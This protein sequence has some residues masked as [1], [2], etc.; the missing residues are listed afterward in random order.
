MVSWIESELGDAFDL[1]HV[2]PRNN[3][4]RTYMNDVQ[5]GPGLYIHGD[6]AIAK[7]GRFIAGIGSKAIIITG[8]KSYQAAGHLLE[9]SLEKADVIFEVVAYSGENSDQEASRI[10]T[11]V[12]KDRDLVLG[13]GGGKVMDLGKLVAE[14]LR[15]PYVTVPTLASNCAPTVPVAVVYHPDGSYKEARVFSRPP[16]LTV[17]DDSVVGSAPLKYFLSGLGDTLAKKYEARISALESS[18]ILAQTGLKIADMIGDRILDTSQEALGQLQRGILGAEARNLFDAIVLLGGMVGGIGGDSCRAAA[19]HALHDA[20]TSLGVM[21]TVTHG[22]KV[23]YG[24]LVQLAIENRSDKELWELK[25]L[26]NDLNLPCNW[27]QLSGERSD[28]ETF[29]EVAER[30]LRIGSSMYRMLHPIN[31]DIVVDA[32]RRVE[33]L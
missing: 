6:N 28:E 9:K 33:N 23:A 14:L 27:R 13:L 15:L 7:S 1:K 10:A 24:I 11:L 22:Q 4:E 30:S 5:A 8:H 18:S 26:F 21:Q 31:P 12:S 3:E 32:M 17:V 19:A 16:L 20:L 2:A 25:R 29:C